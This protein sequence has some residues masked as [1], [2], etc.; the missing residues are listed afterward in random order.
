MVLLM[1]LLMSH[2]FFKQEP[3]N[4][5]D[6][7]CV[8]PV[9]KSRDLKQAVCCIL[10]KGSISYQVGTIKVMPLFKNCCDYTELF[11][12]IGECLGP[13]SHQGAPKLHIQPLLR[14]LKMSVLSVAISC[15]YYTPYML[16]NECWL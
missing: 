10:V 14:R 12:A 13:P 16:K 3:C 8:T 6:F 1:S 5:V 9:C 2:I 7:Q 15:V 11:L 4:L